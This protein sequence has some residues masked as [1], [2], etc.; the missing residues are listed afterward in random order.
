MSQQPPSGPEEP[1]G[2]SYNPP[3]SG[4]PGQGGPP[5]GNQPS[6][7]PM[8]QQPPGWHSSGYGTPGGPGSQEER[9]WAM[10]CHLAAFAGFIVPVIGSVVGPLVAWLIKRDI[11]P[12]VDDQ[13]KE[14]LNFQLS[15]LLYGVICLALIFVIIGFFLLIALVIFDFV[16]IIL[17]AIEA[18]KGRAYRYPLCIRFVR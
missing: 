17:A 16:M 2:P 10:L 9:N 5:P 18:N 7:P 8:P 13:G 12:L 3:P 14:S 4:P 6:Y 15:V 1:Q 11:W